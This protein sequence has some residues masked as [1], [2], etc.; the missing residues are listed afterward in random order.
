MSESKQIP[1]LEN[2]QKWMQ[3]AL[4]QPYATTSIEEIVKDSERLNAKAH[5]AIYQQSYVARL[6]ECMS[7][8]FSA[9]EYSL[10]KDLFRQFVDEY[11]KIYPSNS[12]TL[13]DLGKQFSKY[14]NETR[15][16]KDQE[17]KEDWPD[18]LI[19]L[20]DF[21]YHLVYLF[22][23]MNDEICEPADENTLDNELR[24][25]PVFESFQFHFPV[26]QY[27]SAFRNEQNP[28][29]PFEKPSWCMVFRV[30]YMIGFRTLNYWQY[31]F[32]QHFKINQNVA[33]TIS[34]IAKESQNEVEMVQRFWL[35]W[36]KHWLELGLFS[37][38]AFPN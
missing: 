24:L 28:Q 10:G 14:L 12:Y 22:D 18:F 35:E 15:P 37:I 29:L 31:Q 2:I 17:K 26:P 4:L 11:L 34:I 8:Q 6:R 32:L 1:S 30:N 7:K 5:L 25:V 3:S 16:D 20:A 21:E 27:Y 13:M 23:V 9:L 38:K 19:E 36:R 33:Q